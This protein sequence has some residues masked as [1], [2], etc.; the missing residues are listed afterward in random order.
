MKKYRR[1]TI[2]LATG[3]LLFA[4]LE[5]LGIYYGKYASARVPET[6]ENAQKPVKDPLKTSQ[7]LRKKLNEMTPAGVHIIVDTAQNRLYLKKGD[8]LL[9]E[10]II[11]AGSGSKLEDPEQKREWVFDTPKGVFSVKSKQKNPM[12]VKPDWAYVEEGKKP[13]VNRQDRFEAGV[14]GDY[15]LGFGNGYFIHGT[16]YS[17]ML[18]RNVS[19]GCIRVGSKDLEAIFATAE[20]GTKIYIF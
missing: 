1:M 20:I 13:P 19:H 15:A 9:R 10:A 3:V 17:R 11:S 7:A 16:L 12:W 6:E 18:G 8:T 14:L 2:I 4:V 5:V